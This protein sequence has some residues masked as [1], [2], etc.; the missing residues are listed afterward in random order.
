M[1]HK[2]TDQKTAGTAPVDGDDTRESQY[3]GKTIGVALALTSVGFLVLESIVC[4]FSQRTDPWHGYLSFTLVV[5]LGV[6]LLLVTAFHSSPCVRSVS[7]LRNTLGILYA[8]QVFMA[9]V[10]AAG[11]WSVGQDLWRGQVG[12]IVLIAVVDCFIAGRTFFLDRQSLAAVDNVTESTNETRQ[13]PPQG[14]SPVLVASLSFALLIV[15]AFA[16]SCASSFTYYLTTKSSLLSYLAP[17][18]LN[19]RILSD[20]AGEAMARLFLL[21]V[22]H[23]GVLLVLRIRARSVRTVVLA[24]MLALAAWGYYWVMTQ[25]AVEYA[26]IWYGQ[27]NWAP[28]L[29]CSA[30]VVPL[31]LPFVYV[32][33]LSRSI[34][35]T[36]VGNTD[37][38]VEQTKKL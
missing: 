32:Q 20:C 27:P 22:I 1:E 2:E 28:Q 5:L 33:Y 18:D 31:I 17:A 23:A 13:S 7:F 24:C 30:W 15:L 12:G 35:A 6:V 9:L 34:H 19:R 21:C 8:A 38:V 37:D 10:F 3:G 16:W 4:F 26:R 11:L 25:S 29:F 36:L 14:L